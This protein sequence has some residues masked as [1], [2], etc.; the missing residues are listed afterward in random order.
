MY[1]NPKLM[2]GLEIGYSGVK[3]DAG[4][5]WKKASLIGMPIEIKAAQSKETNSAK[6]PF[7]TKPDSKTVEFPWV[8]DATIILV[9]FIHRAIEAVLGSSP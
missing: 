6:N 4:L 3:I 8:G 1:A 9:K 7:M 5:C 2:T